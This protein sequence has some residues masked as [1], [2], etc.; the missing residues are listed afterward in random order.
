MQTEHSI[1]RPGAAHHVLGQRRKTLLAGI[2]LA[3]GIAGGLALLL[4]GCG[5]GS[6]APASSPPV[7][8]VP[9]PQIADVQKIMQPA[10][11]T[12]NDDMVVAISDRAGFLLVVF[13]AHHA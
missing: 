9:A 7:A 2:F 11:N 5:G 6:N 13:R 12:L 3:L 1:R 4:V 10:T 8:T